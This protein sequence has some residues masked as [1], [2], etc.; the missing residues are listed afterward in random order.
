[1]LQ[2][3]ELFLLAAE[4][5]NFSKAAERAYV[6]QQCLSDHIK[7]L[8]SSYGVPLFYRKPQIALTPY[9][10]ALQ[11]SVQNIK[12]IETNLEHE[13]QAIAGEERGEFSFGINATRARSL[14][15]DIYPAFYARYPQIHVNVRLNETRM[16]E[17]QLLN[18]KLDMCLGIDAIIQPRIASR[19]IGPNPLYCVCSVQTLEEVL[20]L[21]GSDLP[22]YLMKGIDLTSM[23]EIPFLLCLPESTTRSLIDQTLSQ[24]NIYLKNT[25]AISDYSTHFELC[26]NNCMA[27]ICPTAAVELAIQQNRLLSYKQQL[28]ILPVKNFQDSLNIHLLYQKNLQFTGYMNYFVE[29]LI[30]AITRQNLTAARYIE[31]QFSKR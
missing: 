11:S 8:E 30:Q 28:V 10:K 22:P 14:L 19:M 21:D 6:T 16:M 27:T 31:L 1:M 24:Q 26:A 5:L 7:R 20:H 4:E 13:F 25:L 12:L 9:G 15:P 2:S 23:Q 18:G 3:F 17:T 29:L